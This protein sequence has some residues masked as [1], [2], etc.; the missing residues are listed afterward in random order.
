MDK[1]VISPPAGST[2]N[3]V[4]A[5]DRPWKIGHFDSV[6]LNG[7]DLGTYLSESTGYGIV[8]GCTPSIAGLTVTVAAGVV[9]LA[10]GTR[11]EISASTVTLDTADASNP[12]I[13][14]VYITSAGVVAK[15]TGTAAASPSAPALPANG[16][17]VATV[18]VAA[19]ANTGT[20]ADMRGML[21]RWYNAGV[22]NVK[23]F[24]AVGDG[25]HDD[26]A[27]IQAAVNY[28]DTIVISGICLITSTISIS[29]PIKILSA[30]NNSGFK[31]TTDFDVLKINNASGV[32]VDGLKFIGVTPTTSG[33]PGNHTLSLSGCSNFEIKNN[34]F[35]NVN[36]ESA[37][38]VDTCEDGVIYQNKIDTYSFSGILIYNESK[39]VLIKNNTILNNVNTSQGY[40]I[41]CTCS[42]NRAYPDDIK[43]IGNFVKNNHAW[44]GIMSHGGNNIEIVLNTCE[45]CR[46]GIDCSAVYKNAYSV[47]KNYI[48]ADNVLIGT[49]DT[50]IAGTNINEGIIFG[51]DSDLQSDK[52][53]IS[54]N[55]IKG[56]K[57][58]T[59]ESNGGIKVQ[60]ANNV[61][62]ESNN[63]Y[64]AKHGISLKS[65]IGIS[66]NI[67]IHGNCLKDTP[68]SPILF[69]QG[70]FDGV[71]ITNNFFTNSTKINSNFIGFATNLTSFLNCYEYKNEVI[72]LVRTPISTS[73]RSG[74][75]FEILTA[76]SPSQE[77]CVYKKGDK[78]YQENPST[79]VGWVAMNTGINVSTEWTASTSVPRGKMLYSDN[80]A[81]VVVKAGTT[82]ADAP[83]D[84]TGEPF[85]DG[86]AQLMYVGDKTITFKQ[87]G[88][89]ES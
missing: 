14:L 42:A 10:D 61:I 26:T 55:I 83:T 68:T 48:I 74:F 87:F 50:S 70:I 60:N 36:M 64:D 2:Q 9:H 59:S 17:S 76:L 71:A 49:T 40:G 23:D 69:I 3:S 21:A 62:V 46:C 29:K 77:L 39:R 80:N 78:I 7:G 35:T 27:A 85:A 65:S 79:Y 33:D 5:A 31:H 34:D 16:I 37:I 47:Q 18:S 82:G 30:N 72:N 56:F 43:I 58:G 66:K 15:V 8:S 19:N 67:N 89:I 52:C 86:S 38:F 12:R 51:F 73:Y 57:I 81:Y 44:D 28:G 24:G 20:V 75:H 4:G 25:E 63:I 11:K 13:D 22:V 54:R 88:T 41:E 32:V 45:D 1:Y 53:I 6:K 84:T